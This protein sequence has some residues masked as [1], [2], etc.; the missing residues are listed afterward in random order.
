MNAKLRCKW[1]IDYVFRI[2]I[3]RNYD[4]KN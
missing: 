2:F 4:E 3:R 1:L